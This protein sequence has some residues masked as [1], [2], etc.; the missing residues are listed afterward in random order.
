MMVVTSLLPSWALEYPS[1]LSVLY[2]IVKQKSQRG[3]KNERT[4]NVIFFLILRKHKL[5]GT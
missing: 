1:Y 3:E 5:E 2:L 4:L